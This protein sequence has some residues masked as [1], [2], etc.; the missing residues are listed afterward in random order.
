[1]FYWSGVTRR[2]VREGVIRGLCR[3]LEFILRPSLKWESRCGR[4][5]EE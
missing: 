4:K 5:E 1:M 2:L 3:L